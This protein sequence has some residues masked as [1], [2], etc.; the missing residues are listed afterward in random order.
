VQLRSSDPTLF[1]YPP[2]IAAMGDAATA[3]HNNANG[4]T[5]TGLSWDV[6]QAE[7]AVAVT[8]PEARGEDICYLQYS[9]GSTRFPH[10]VAVTHASLLNNLAGHG[11]ACRSPTTAA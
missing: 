5:C 9:S 2:E 8:L 10:G 6:L 3:A 7:P 1:F 11:Q 4:T